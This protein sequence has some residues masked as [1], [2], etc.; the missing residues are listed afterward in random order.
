MLN[1]AGS[2]KPHS[3]SGRPRRIFADRPVSGDTTPAELAYEICQST[4]AAICN[5][6]AALYT[7]AAG[8]TSAPGTVNSPVF[9]PVAGTYAFARG[10]NCDQFQR[11]RGQLAT[12]TVVLSAQP[13]ANVV[14]TMN[15]NL[16]AEG[17]IRMTGGYGGTGLDYSG[18]ML[19]NDATCKNLRRLVC[20]EQ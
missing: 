11:R 4:S 12:F 6:F 5:T 17:R 18:A 8:A 2:K 7:S 14:L 19:G 1:P 20:V 3:P 9:A 15:S 13:T 16:E 10:R